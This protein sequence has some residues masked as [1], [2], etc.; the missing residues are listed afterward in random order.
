LLDSLR[1]TRSATWQGE[2]DYD[3]GVN[4]D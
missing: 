1:V 2:H 4:N 3:K